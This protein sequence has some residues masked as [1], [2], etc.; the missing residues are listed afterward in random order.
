MGRVQDKTA[1]V[2]GAAMGLGKA[3]ALRLAEEGARLVL[4]DIDAEGL[5]GTASEIAARGG[6]A[7]TVGGDLTEEP[8]AAALIDRAMADFGQIDILVNNVG[9]SRNTK[10]WEMSVEDWDFVLRLNLRATFL[11]TR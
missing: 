11:C 2:T 8:A 3:I 9:G 1:I 5:A 10:I 4:G 6:T 7:V